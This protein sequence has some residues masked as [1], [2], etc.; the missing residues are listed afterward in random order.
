MLPENAQSAMG[1]WHCH[2][3][4]SGDWNHDSFLEEVIFKLSPNKGSQQGEGDDCQ[5]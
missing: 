5:R 3:N 2:L 1:M 4:S